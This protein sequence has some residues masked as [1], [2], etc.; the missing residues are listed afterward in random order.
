MRS[1]KKFLPVLLE[2]LDPWLFF[3][4]AATMLA[5]WTRPAV[6]QPNVN[7]PHLASAYPAGSQQGNHGDQSGEDSH[8]RGSLP[9][10]ASY[11]FFA[12]GLL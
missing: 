10:S 11:F 9:R 6:T 2:D 5:S 8:A 3:L 1:L 12:A 4:I 7:R